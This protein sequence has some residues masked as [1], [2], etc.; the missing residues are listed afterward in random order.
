MRDGQPPQPGSDDKP[1]KCGTN[2]TVVIERHC[3]N[4]RSLLAVIETWRPAPLMPLCK[5]GCGSSDT[6][7]GLGVYAIR[8]NDILR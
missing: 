3:R 4:G 8:L 1:C 2:A 7:I 6:F 5:I